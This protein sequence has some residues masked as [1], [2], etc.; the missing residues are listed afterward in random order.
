MSVCRKA[1]PPLL[2]AMLWLGPVTM[3]RISA[4]TLEPEPLWTYEAA[5]EIRPE[6]APT[7]SFDGAGWF[8]RSKEIPARRLAIDAA[9]G[10]TGDPQAAGLPLPLNG[11]VLLGDYQVGDICFNTCFVAH[12]EIHRQDDAGRLLWSRALPPSSAFGATLGVASLHEWPG[13]IAV[14]SGGVVQALDA[15]TGAVRWVA[16]LP[17]CV[18][19]SFVKGAV[20]RLTC[21]ARS[22]LARLESDGSFAWQS[23]AVGSLRGASALGGGRFALLQARSSEFDWRVLSA[24]GEVLGEMTIGLDPLLLQRPQLRAI[25][26]D[27]SVIAVSGGA[28]SRVW[29]L[30]L[31]DTTP[32]WVRSFDA[33][34]VRSLEL[35]G[36]DLSGGQILLQ[37]RLPTRGQVL[38]LAAADG[39]TRWT[40]ALAEGRQP[41]LAPEGFSHHALTGATLALGM[42]DAASGATAGWV[43]LDLALGVVRWQRAEVALP[44]RRES[45]GFVRDQRIYDVQ[46]SARDPQHPRLE[47]R[48]LGLDGQ[49]EQQAMIALPARRTPEDPRLRLEHNADRILIALERFDGGAD[50]PGWAVVDRH[51]LA[52]LALLP[53]LSHVELADRGHA[54]LELYEYPS[55]RRIHYFSGSAAADWTVELPSGSTLHA[56]YADGVLARLGSAPGMGT[57]VVGTDGTP[58][59]SMPEAAGEGQ[60][61]RTSE[62]SFAALSDQLRLRSG[63]DGSVLQT[64]AIAPLRDALVLDLQS[65]VLSVSGAAEGRHLRR[66]YRSA[67]LLPVA[68]LDSPFGSLVVTDPPASG[69]PLRGWQQ[70]ATSTT[71]AG[72]LEQVELAS[73][74]A[75]VLVRRNLLRLRPRTAIAGG[76]EALF[77]GSDRVIVGEY[78]S[79][80]QVGVVRYAAYGIPR[81]NGTAALRLSLSGSGRD[82]QPFVL[83]ISND[84]PDATRVRLQAAAPGHGV[85]LRRLSCD[86]AVAAQACAETAGDGLPD[87]FAVPAGAVA[88]F[89]VE[90][91]PLSASYNTPTPL[92]FAVDADAHTNEVERADNHGVLLLTTGL[93]NNGFE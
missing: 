87:D 82:R 14:A 29:W 17:G 81:L 53:R 35:L 26:A 77:V 76:R 27:Q 66:L 6:P 43:G 31:G 34:E 41:A 19:G 42:V 69:T 59:F 9:T 92:E 91:R 1:A 7:L 30:Q 86:T 33:A 78:Q 89:T 62:G 48:V 23:S 38:A 46:Y 44:V 60:I 50:E 90:P 67:D 63:T 39:S 20:L 84:G 32:R 93:F 36:G 64:A 37:T 56:V 58:R 61:R 70:A 24:E 74:G 22:G 8:T 57:T 68:L 85:L 72:V 47:L 83:A 12:E 45:A 54:L 80:A 21:G 79:R 10:A 88:R 3:Q 73:G 18:V 28:Q 40:H 55:F 13:L 15:S 65:A 71:L 11:G 5:T 4:A 52:L 16:S 75:P 49:L 25:G 2:M 51:S